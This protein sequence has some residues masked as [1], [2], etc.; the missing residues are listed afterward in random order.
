MEWVIGFLSNFLEESALLVRVFVIGSIPAVMTALGSIPVLLGA[1]LSEKVRDTGMGFAAGVMIVASF[2]SLLLPAME[3]G[4][5][6]AGIVGFLIGAGLIKALDALLPHMHWVK[7]FEGSHRLFEKELLVALAMVV[8]NVPEGIAV[9][10]AATRSSADGLVL[11]LAIGLQDVPEGLAVALPLVT[12]RGKW[13]AFFVGVMSGVAEAV[14]ALLPPM[15]IEH[16]EL[17]L[18]FMMALAA[19]AMVYV[20]IHEVVPEIYGHE[21]D[22]PSTL[23]F[24]AGFVAMLLLDTALS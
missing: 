13:I 14:S 8:H 3:L 5:F 20:V 22:E 24:F 21:H 12:S 16:A 9:G 7:G 1:S 10:V 15:V 6:P 2:T 11:A 17:A 23:G 18:P 4:G 19:G